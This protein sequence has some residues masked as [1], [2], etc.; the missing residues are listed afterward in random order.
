MIEL[1]ID[2]E[3]RDKIPQLTDEELEIDPNGTN[4]IINDTNKDYT[5]IN[6]ISTQE[7]SNDIDKNSDIIEIKEKIV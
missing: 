6:E 1:K 5:P 4:V 7:Q 2:P 3:F